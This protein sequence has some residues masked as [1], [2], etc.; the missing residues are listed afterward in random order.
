[1]EIWFKSGP[2]VVS[3]PL[4]DQGWSWRCRTFAY[5]VQDLEFDPQNLEWGERRHV[6]IAA[7]KWNAG[8]CNSVN[9]FLLHIPYLKK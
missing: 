4:E 7:A 2:N 3:L 1:M 6:P 8:I 5:Y 9:L